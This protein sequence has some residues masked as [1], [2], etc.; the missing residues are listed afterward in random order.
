[1][2]SMSGSQQAAIFLLML[3]EDR[4]AEI[5]RHVST[6]E[7]EQIGQAMTAIKDVQINQAVSVIE[8]FETEVTSQLPVALETPNYVRKLLVS[9]LGDQNGKTLADKL[10]GGEK[11]LDLTSLRWLE[12]DTV[13]HL[14]KEEHPQII[15]ITLAHMN[16]EQASYV[17]DKLDPALQ[18]DIALRIANMDKIPQA[19]LTELQEIL[20]RKQAHSANFK[21]KQVD[22]AKRVA[23]LIN[24]LSEESEKRVVSLLAQN[25]PA[26]AERIK[27]LMFVFENLSDLDDKG[28]QRLMREVSTDILAV[29]LKGASEAMRVK[30]M[31]NMSKRAG[32]MLLEDMESRGP[33]KLSEVDQ[34]Q[35]DMVAIARRLAEEGEINLGSKGEEYV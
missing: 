27:E 18:E 20:N 16:V 26:M 21:A 3:G 10:L 17:L 32:E 22:G 2:T 31:K 5:L 14:L 15:A 28:M 6:E 8:R 23:D 34:A 7:V 19:A 25:D 24:G 11:E 12:L 29:A 1:M 13:V 4:A 30:I 33:V 35:K 9:A